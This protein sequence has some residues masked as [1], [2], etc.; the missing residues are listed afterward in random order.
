MYQKQVTGFDITMD[1]IGWMHVQ[2]ASQNL[3]HKILD[4]V[5]W[6]VLP[7]VNDSMQIRLHQL[8]YDVNV[9]VACA[10]LRFEQIHQAH[11]IFV[12]EEFCFISKCT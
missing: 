8:C 11:Y 10:G 4:V 1:N 2:Q 3:V 7:R 12:L 9:S 6:Q 5:V